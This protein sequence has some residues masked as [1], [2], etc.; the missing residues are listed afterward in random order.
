MKKFWLAISLLL[1][2]SIIPASAFA[3]TPV[4]YCSFDVEPGG[5]GSFDDPWICEDSTQLGNIV[6]EICA[7]NEYAIL[8]QT[9]PSGYYRHVIED[10]EDAACA[11]TSSVFYYGYPPDTGLAIPGPLM[12]GGLALLGVG[13]VGGGYLVY[14]KRYA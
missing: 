12:V 2:L 1:L 5:D 4:Y 7:H 6:T 11:V 8:Y 14:R 13:L 9:V 3:S 10:P